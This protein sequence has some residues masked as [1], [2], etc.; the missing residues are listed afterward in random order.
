MCENIIKLLEENKTSLDDLLRKLIDNSNIPLDSKQYFKLLRHNANLHYENTQ[1][2]VHLTSSLHRKIVRDTNF[3]E[4]II[5]KNMKKQN[6][7]SNA[8]KKSSK[9]IMQHKNISS[10]ICL[11]GIDTTA[12]PYLLNKSKSDTCLALLRR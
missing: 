9:L 11:S 7:K 4:N 1:L 5:E 3:T 8:V 2:K 6:I 12:S 10:K